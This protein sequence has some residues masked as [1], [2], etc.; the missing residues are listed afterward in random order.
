MDREKNLIIHQE[1]ERLLKAGHIREVRYPDWIANVVLVPKPGGKWHMCVDF[2]DL[3][4]ACPKDLYPLPRID[5]LVDS[6]AG[7]ER[8]S[9][10]D[11]YQGYNQIKLA[12]EDHEKTSFIT[13]RGLYCYNVIPFGLKNAGATYQRSDKQHTK[14]L[15]E[16]FDQLRKYGVK[17]NPQKC[18]FGVEGGKFLGYLV[19][20]R[21]RSQS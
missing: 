15:K 16:C 14:D 11:A 2:T 7:C 8:L 21:D 1:V 10:L 4:K 3:N 17:L 20:L 18:T 6:T 19:T 12:K 5:Q 13:E 9:M